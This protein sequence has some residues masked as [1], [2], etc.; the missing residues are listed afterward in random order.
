MLSL[1]EVESFV[2]TDENGDHQYGFSLKIHERAAD[3]AMVPKVLLLLTS[4]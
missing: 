2:T 1:P 4:W 3:G